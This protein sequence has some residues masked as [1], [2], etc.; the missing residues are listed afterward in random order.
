MEQG[1]CAGP[2]TCG[3]PLVSHLGPG[4]AALEC[5][6]Q[7]PAGS[8]W[9]TALLRCENVK[10]DKQQ[11]S[12]GLGVVVHMVGKVDRGF[13]LHHLHPPMVKDHHLYFGG[14]LRL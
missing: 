8:T 1:G 9:R 2:G 7:M 6:S 3:E 13:G 4:A 12:N 11:P 5:P 14:I 10:H